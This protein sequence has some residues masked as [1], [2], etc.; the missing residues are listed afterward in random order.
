[1]SNKSE[2]HVIAEA[3]LANIRVLEMLIN[4]LPDQT[5]QEVAKVVEKATPVPVPVQAAPVEPA[6]TITITAAPT[7]VVTAPAPV[8][9]QMPAAPFPAVAVTPAVPVPAPIP[10][11]PVAQATVDIP[12]KDQKGL[13][14]WAM[15]KYRQL[16]RERGAKMQDVM[17]ELGIGNINEVD[18]SKYAAFFTAV[19]AL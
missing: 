2:I 3:V 1:M 16:G 7:P 15:D 9:P 17:K 10:A 11:G 12:F 6:P 4:K 8:A 14:M 18:P 19:E 13:S 5:R